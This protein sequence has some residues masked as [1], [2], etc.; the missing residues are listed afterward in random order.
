MH[1]AS[2]AMTPDF[3]STN[4]HELLLLGT[5][6]ASG[7]SH[8][9]FFRNKDSLLGS[10][11]IACESTRSPFG[12]TPSRLKPDVVAVIVNITYKL[13]LQRTSSIL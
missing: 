3:V 7:P 8:I 9:T 12:M 5:I 13:S 1:I 10:Y 11:D 6:K 4:F 2:S